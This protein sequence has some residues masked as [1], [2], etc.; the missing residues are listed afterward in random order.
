MLDRKLLAELR[1]Q[2]NHR[3]FLYGGFLESIVPELKATTEAEGKAF[4]YH[5]AKST[6]AQAFLR[7]RTEGGLRNNTLGYNGALIH[8]LWRCRWVLRSLTPMH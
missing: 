2:R 3:I 5:I 6:E 7:R 1:R 8:H 4:V